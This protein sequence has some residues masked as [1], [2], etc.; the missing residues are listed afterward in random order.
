MMKYNPE[1]QTIVPRF[2]EAAYSAKD[3]YPLR[4]EYPEM[5]GGDTI[6]ANTPTLLRN[7]EYVLTYTLLKGGSPEQRA[8]LEAL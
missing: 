5:E 6:I 4:V 2:K 3:I 1:T 8:Y 7:G